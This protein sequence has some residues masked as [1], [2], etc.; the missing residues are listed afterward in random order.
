MAYGSPH[1]SGGMAGT[2]GRV[3]TMGEGFSP[4]TFPC[5]TRT[6]TVAGPLSTLT[7]TVTSPLR[8]FDMFH[9]PYKR[10]DHAAGLFA[11]VAAAFLSPPTA[12]RESRSAGVGPA[13]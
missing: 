13:R 8:T 9:A 6:V 1:R 11:A 5:L 3:T 2:S 7:L 12:G 10:W 4:L